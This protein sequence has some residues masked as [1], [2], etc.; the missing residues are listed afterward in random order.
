MVALALFGDARRTRD[1][2]AELRSLGGPPCL[3][4][5]WDAKKGVHDPTHGNLK[6]FIDDAD[7]L[8][9]ELRR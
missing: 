4:A 3:D 1:V 8:T 5:F 6:R 7:R 9:R 2:P